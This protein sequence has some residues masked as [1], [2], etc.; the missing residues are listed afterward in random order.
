MSDKK[1]E[2]STAQSEAMALSAALF[3]ECRVV[4]DFVSSYVRT[5]IP[6]P[7]TLS[8]ADQVILR[9]FLRIDA[10][11]R[12]LAK[13]NSPADF[14][15]VSSGCRALLEVAVDIVLLSKNRSDFVKLVAWEESAKL[16]HAQAVET[17]CLKT[18]KDFS[19]TNP[20]MAQF[21]LDFRQVVEANRQKYGWKKNGK[22]GHV[23]RWT[24][25]GLAADC[26]VADQSQKLFAF[27]EFYE[28]RY[29]ELCWNVHGS[30]L[31][32]A[33]VGVDAFPFLAGQAF[34]ECA[35]LGQVAGEVVLKSLGQWDTE[36]EKAFSKLAEHRTL[37]AYLTLHRGG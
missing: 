21:L 13:L 25:Q 6:E 19:K 7:T 24:A 16:K 22:I 23:D 12:T 1:L 14:Q 36:V 18:K 27:E 15:A 4:S 34:R 2:L 37:T 32:V 5:R 9:Q 17:F 11:L 33:P 8:E 20:E 35:Q 26:I 3:A 28:S 29:R 10:W 31:V 30:G